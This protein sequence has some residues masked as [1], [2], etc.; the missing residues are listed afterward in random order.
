MTLDL[1]P[2]HSGFR[3]DSFGQAYNE[4]AFKYFL[5]VDR[6][7]IR[8]SERSILLV[9]VS[10]REQSGRNAPLTEEMAA[11]LFAGLGASVREVDFIGWYR[12]DRV[13]GAVL[14]QAAGASAELRDL[15]AH[16]VLKSL[17]KHAPRHHSANL[18]VR[19][20]VLGGKDAQ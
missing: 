1:I 14:P 7:R 16:R 8:R 3:S 4:A 6:R 9:L 11:Q 19:V 10:V 5:D 2:A 12:H 18:R 17:Q 13:I 15:I 20:A